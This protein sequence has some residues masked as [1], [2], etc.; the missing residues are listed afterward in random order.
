MFIEKVYGLSATNISL[1]DR[2]TMLA[3]IVPERLIRTRNPQARRNIDNILN[4]NLNF[5]DEDLIEQIARKIQQ[6]KRVCFLC[7]FNLLFT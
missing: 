6:A 1:N 7:I 5:D 3:A 4:Q 2:F